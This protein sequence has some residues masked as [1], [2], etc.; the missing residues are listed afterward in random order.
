MKKLCFTLSAYRSEK[1]I[2]S[3]YTLFD[4]NLF[5][6]VEIFYPYNISMEKIT[7]YTESLNELFKRYDIEH[8]MHLP[9]GRDSN[10]SQDNPEVWERYLKAI[11]YGKM[12]NVNKFTLHLGSSNESNLINVSK[13]LKKLCEYAY[14]GNIMIENMPSRAEYGATLAEFQEI[15]KLVDMP[16]CK[17]IYDTGHGHVA[18]NDM[19]AEVNFLHVL[20]PY[21]YHIHLN[22]NN[23]ESDM[24]APIGE[25]NIN[26]YQLF[27][28]LAD[29]YE[30]VC[31]EILYKDVNDLRKYYKDVQ[32][33]I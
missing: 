20:K 9:F 17:L 31:I 15:F 8:V 21:L 29:Y 13:K 27:K 6:A 10:F 1:D 25:G 33:F 2:K 22:D 16:N 5:Q 28:E 18:F 11:D 32:K 12:F 7:E 26:F 30:L 19:K 24:H 23:G 14:P 3:F 4:N